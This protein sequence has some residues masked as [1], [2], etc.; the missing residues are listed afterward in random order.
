MQTFEYV[1]EHRR[2]RYSSKT[3]MVLEHRMLLDMNPA[4][5]LHPPAE[6][7]RLVTVLAALA[8]PARMAI[9]RTLAGAGEAAC[10]RLQD[11]AGLQISRSTFSHHQRV[12][13]EA[14]I[15]RVRLSGSERLLAL[16]RDD[17]DVCF[18][19]LLDAVLDT[20]DQLVAPAPAGRGAM[21]GRSSWAERPGSASTPPSAGQ[22]A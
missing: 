17:L 20:P 13:R 22:P 11:K 12:L 10:H 8:D 9:V 21:A 15:V 14:G 1:D 6:E 7:L 3:T 4:D 19:G 2:L 18:P 16:R 5:G